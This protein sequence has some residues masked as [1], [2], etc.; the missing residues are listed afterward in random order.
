MWELLLNDK[1]V[2]VEA[3]YC[4]NLQVFIEAKTTIG[5]KSAAQKLYA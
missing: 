5:W 4:C 2:Y 3:S 1:F